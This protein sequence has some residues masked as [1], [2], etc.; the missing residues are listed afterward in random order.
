MRRALPRTSPCM[1]AMLTAALGCAEEAPVLEP[2]VEVP[3]AESAAYPYEGIDELELSIARAGDGE[4]LALASAAAGEPLVLANVPFGEDLVVHLSGKAAG[5]EISYGRTCPIDVTADAPALQPRLYFARIV[6]WGAIPAATPRAPTRTG[7]HGYATA[8]GGAVFLGGD[9]D[10]VEIFDPVRASDFA[11]LAPQPIRRRGTV[12]VPLGND[13]ALIVGGLDQAGDAVPRVE[14]LDPGASTAGRQLEA[15]D[16][17]ALAAHA[18][19]RLVDGTAIVAGGETQDAPGAPFAVSGSAWIFRIGAGG[20][21]EAPERLRAL[22]Q[23]PRGHHTMTRLGN[24]LGA[25]VLV[26][27]GRDAASQPVAQAELYRPLR[28]TFEP[29]DGATLQTPRWDHVAV[30]MPGGFVLVL[31]GMAADPITGAA[32]PAPSLELYD[33]VQ[34]TFAPAGILPEGAGLTEMTVT[35]LPDGRVLLAGGRDASGQPVATVLI[36]RLDPI[37]GQVDLSPSHS[38][39]VP[40]AGHSA[41]SLC[42]GT[43]LVV[44]GTDDAGASAVRYN[45]P[46]AGRR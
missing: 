26:V 35:P 12:L 33:P 27:G 46:S 15:F 13:T 22:M 2:I 18:G 16:G 23:V 17:P 11:L 8:T 1:L 28:E 9:G 45:P 30:R 32:V 31:G 37:D 14:V 4:P 29:I 42:D 40:R 41:V 20:V 7:G 6:R 39:Q 5:V 36:A 3:A 24:E 25:D 44:G 38:L 10:G 21:L 34:G 43:I 19:V